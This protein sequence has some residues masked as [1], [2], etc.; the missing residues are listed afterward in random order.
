MDE[1][2]QMDRARPRA[3]RDDPPRTADVLRAG[4]LG[5]LALGALWMFANEILLVFFAV[6]L[7]CGLRGAAAPICARTPLSIGMA[8]LLVALGLLLLAVGTGVLLG[9]R[10]VDQAHALGGAM[11]EQW[12]HFKDMLGATSAGQF[13]LA[14]LPQ[15]GKGGGGAMPALHVAGATLGGIGTT[16]VVLATAF[17]FAASPRLYL[18]GIAHLV[19]F[20]HRER[21]LRA[22]IESGRTLRYWLL[23][24]LVDMLTVGVLSAVGL[25]LVGVP[26]ALV[27]GVITALLTFVPYFG[28]IAAAVPAVLLGLSKGVATGAWAL[29]VYTL[30]HMVEGYVVSPLVQRHMVKLP[31]ALTILALTFAGAAFGPLGIVLG[32]PLAAAGL[33]MVQ[34]LYVNEVLGDTRV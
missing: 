13:L 1:T 19:P 33:V 7:A 14:Q 32:T 30:C 12:G 3:G 17:Y 23:G 6:L 16:V 29:G 24:Q 25:E 26:L 15:I 34:R 11:A 31:P 8:L 28:A 5:A 21:L 22:L 9:P 18:R 4:L 20:G 2:T 10:V 27:L